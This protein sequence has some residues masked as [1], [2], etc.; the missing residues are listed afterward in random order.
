MPFASMTRRLATA[1]L[2][3]ASV[4][5]AGAATADDHHGIARAR[6]L[7]AYPQECGSCHVAY[8]PGMLPA[9]S[10]QR[11]MNNLPRHFGTDASLDAA[12]TRELA[13]WLAANAGTSRRVREEPPQDRITR[14]TWF[15]RKHDEVPAASW[16]LPAVQSPS[17][18]G[19]CHT[20][21]D[22]GDFDEHRV[23][24]PR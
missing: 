14:S 7:P 19:A 23:R 6:M 15:V 16:K 1:G 20:Q 2:M 4:L 3:L 22:Q 9:A 24:I 5:A 11:L 12:T 18:C 13:A 10:W 8:P 17:R 21:A